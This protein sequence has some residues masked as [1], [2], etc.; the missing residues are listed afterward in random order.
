[1]DNIQTSITTHGAIVRQS[2]DLSISSTIPDLWHIAM[3]L[4]DQGNDA[5]ADAVLNTWYLAADMR[6]RILDNNQLFDRIKCQCSDQHNAAELR[7]GRC[8]DCGQPII[9]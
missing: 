2:V 7:E 3:R 5:D 6:D 4:R 8:I 1:M 9:E